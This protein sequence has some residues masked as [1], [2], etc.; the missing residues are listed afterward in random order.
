VKEVE[1]DR[2]SEEVREGQTVQ[3]EEWD[4]KREDESAKQCRRRRGTGNV[5]RRGTGNVRRRG[6]DCIVRIC[7]Y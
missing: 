3:E 1:S 6:L 7:E 2:K 4:R 5:R